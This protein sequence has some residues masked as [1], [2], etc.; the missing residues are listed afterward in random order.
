MRGLRGLG[1][2]ASTVTK[3]CEKKIANLADSPHY[4]GALPLL[5][6]V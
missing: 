4:S 1:G 3:L 6:F 5:F 2:Y